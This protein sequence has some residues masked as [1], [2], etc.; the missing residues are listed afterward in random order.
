MRAV[1][2]KSGTAAP[3]YLHSILVEG[4]EPTLK[5]LLSICEALGVS[6]AYIIHGIDVTPAQLDLLKRMQDAPERIDAV[7]TL[8]AINQP[9][10]LFHYRAA[11]LHLALRRD[12]YT[13]KLS[14]DRSSKDNALSQHC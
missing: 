12:R 7:L 5:N 11:A 9:P 6:A 3:G 8:W 10:N 13:P 1:S 4:K 2:L 14:S